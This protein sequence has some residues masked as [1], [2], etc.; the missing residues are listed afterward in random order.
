M[1]L[2]GRRHLVWSGTAL[3]VHR[4]NADGVKWEVRTWVEAATV[5]FDELSPEVLLDLI[6]SESWVGKAGAYDLAGQ[7]RQH[8][9]L[10]AGA[11]IC[12][13][14]LAPAAIEALDS[15]VAAANV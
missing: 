3:L 10:V 6:D 15:W 11:E 5:E 9:R 4:K 14:G 2:S 8:G 1:R 7:M 12:V 13:L